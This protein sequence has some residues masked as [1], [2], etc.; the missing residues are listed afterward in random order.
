MFVKLV[1][2]IIQYLI[3]RLMSKYMALKIKS[4]IPSEF[5]TIEIICDGG[6][7]YRAFLTAYYKNKRYANESRESLNLNEFI[8]KIIKVAH[9]LY[10]ADIGAENLCNDVFDWADE[11]ELMAMS[12]LYKVKFVIQDEAVDRRTIV[13]YKRHKK[14]QIIHLYRSSYHYTLMVPRTELEEYI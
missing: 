9:E 13:E 5:V 10:E 7:A 2:Q 8:T 1:Y 14:N 4:V 12:K 6:C 3:D 11:P